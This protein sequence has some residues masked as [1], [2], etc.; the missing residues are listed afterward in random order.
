MATTFWLLIGYNFGCVI[1]IDM[2]FNSNGGFLGSGYPMMIAEIEDVRDV[3]IIVLSTQK[4]F[5]VQIHSVVPQIFHTQTKNT[6]LWR[7]NRIFR[8]SLR[9][10]TICS[11]LFLSRPR[12]EG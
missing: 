9:V 12:S 2:M 1:A 6:D 10:L 4:S 8:S 7:Q 11:V 3:A 5:Q